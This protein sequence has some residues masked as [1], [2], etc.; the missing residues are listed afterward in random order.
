MKNY[1]FFFFSNFKLSKEVYYVGDVSPSQS[2]TTN[3]SP[4]PAFPRPPAR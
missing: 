1:F 2:A 3:G 4:P